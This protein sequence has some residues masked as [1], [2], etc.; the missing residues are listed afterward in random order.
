MPTCHVKQIAFPS[1]SPAS[2]LSSALPHLL[3]L[4][5]C[6]GWFTSSPDASHGGRRCWCW[7]RVQLPRPAL[8]DKLFGRCDKWQDGTRLPRMSRSCW[9][10]HIVFCCI[11]QIEMDHI[12]YIHHEPPNWWKSKCEEISNRDNCCS[13]CCHLHHVARMQQMTVVRLDWNPSIAIARSEELSS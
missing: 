7:W 2:S 13:C 4:Q 10:T 3:L 8:H 6:F 1:S 5:S 9:A 11:W 12:R